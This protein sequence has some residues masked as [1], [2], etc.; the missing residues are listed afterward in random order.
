MVPTVYQ[1]VL[2]HQNTIEHT[3]DLWLEKAAISVPQ[4]CSLFDEGL[5]KN[6]AILNLLT[7]TKLAQVESIL[8]FPINYCNKLISIS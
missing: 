5:R 8:S 3:F 1:L 2:E 4:K 7:L 6:A